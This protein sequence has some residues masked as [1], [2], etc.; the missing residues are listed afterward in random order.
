MRAALEHGARPVPNAAPDSSVLGL[1][2]VVLLGSLGALAALAVFAGGGSS[3]DSIVWIGSMVL[4]LACGAA[5]AALAGVLPFPRTSRVGAWSLALLAAF[6]LWQ[7]ASVYWSLAPD[8]SW[9]YFNRS[10]VYLAFAVAGVFAGALCSRRAAAGALALIIAG[11]LVVALAGKV[12]PALYEDGARIARLRS[13]VGFWNALALLFALGVPLALWLATERRRLGLRVLGGVFLYGLLVGILLTYSRSGVLATILAVAL[14]L[15]FAPRRTDSAAV[16]LVAG[17]PAAGI[18]LWAFGQPG[19][20]DDAQS[21]ATRVTDGWQLGLLFALGAALVAG[22][23]YALLRFVPLDLRVRRPRLSRGQAVAAAVVGLVLLTAATIAAAGWFADQARE[24]A[25]PQTDLVTQDPSRLTST[26]SNNRWDWWQEAWTG[27]REAPVR[28]TGAGSF[29]T[30]HRLLRDDPLTVTEP[31]SLPLQFLSETGLVGGLLAGGAAVAGLLAV[32][33]S[34]RRVRPEEQTAALALAI[35][36][37]VYAA[38]SLVDWDW[39]FLA[40]GAPVFAVFGL[41][42]AVDRAGPER[43]RPAWAAAVLAVLLVTVSSLALPWLAKR[44]TAA[45]YDALAAGSA[46]TALDSAKRAEALNPVSVE[47]LLVQSLAADALGDVEATRAALRAAVRLQPANSEAWYEL[48]LFELERAG[49]PDLA[50]QALRELV[51]ARSLR[52]GRPCPRARA[53]VAGMS[54]PL[55]VVDA[56]TLGRERTGDESSVENL[57]REIGTDPGDLRIAAVTRHPERVPPGI[58][59]LVLTARS[60]VARMALRLPLLLRRVSPALAHFLYVVPPLWRGPA[61]VTVPDISFERHPE[62]MTARD[63]ALFRALVPGSTR[64]AERVL[65]PSEW[66][67]R[68]LLEH[69]R[70]PEEKVIVTPWGVDPAFG[71]KGGAV[72][73]PPYILV[74]GA[75]QP[76]KDPLTAL[77]ALARLDPGLRLVFAGPEKQG[78]NEVRRATERLGLD[79]RVDLLGYVSREHLAELYR[80]ARLPRPALALRG[81]RPHRPGGDGERHARGHHQCWVDPRGG[82]GG[83]RAGRAG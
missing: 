67:K 32:V 73:A 18:A 80:G 62:L 15:A 57:L 56:D 35:G 30:T 75:I 69:Y 59:P 46:E 54:R 10:L 24:F 36:V 64:R 76:R 1:A 70:L 27:F 3:D 8:R 53:R 34:V 28:G 16:L 41:L 4:I 82:R 42:L 2:P 23:A 13:P 5:A 33:A 77:E 63:R 7:G 40:L 52:A 58:E 9:D 39:D 37:A 71:P 43:P 20:A 26:S 51:R 17:L 19:V 14:W 50:V 49:R 55:V 68:D 47:P 48:G 60:Q 78:G 44:E 38:H 83:R 61:V 11:A 81:L 22:A 31:H 74:V 12:I 72:E 79:G 25:N 65:T 66:T 21:Y 45:A 29:E 6:V